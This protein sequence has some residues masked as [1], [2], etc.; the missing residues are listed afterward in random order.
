MGEGLDVGDEAGQ[1]QQLGGPAVKDQQLPQESVVLSSILSLDASKRNPVHF[2]TSHTIIT[3]C[4]STVVI[5]DTTTNEKQYL[6]GKDEGGIGA[7]AV[8]PAREL[9]AVAEKCRT[10]APNVYLYSYPELE[11]MMSLEKG[12]E[13]A[14]SAATFDIK[15]DMLATVREAPIYSFDGHAYQC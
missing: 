10:R 7:V 14:Y 2:L 15:G 3:F 8:H 13:Q 6:W 12:T 5:L 11:L 4:G 9:F 1:E